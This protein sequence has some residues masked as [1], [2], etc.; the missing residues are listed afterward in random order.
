MVAQETV[1]KKY[2]AIMML[3]LVQGCDGD[4]RDVTDDKLSTYIPAGIYQGTDNPTGETSLPADAMI[5]SDGRVA[6]IT[7]DVPRVFIGTASGAFIPGKVYTDTVS[8]PVTVQLTI[9]SGDI[10]SGTY[11]SSSGDGTFDLLANPELY[12]RPSSLEKLEGEW[13]DD[14]FTSIAGTTTWVI[15]ADGT[16]TVSSTSGCTAEGAF[17]TIDPVKNEYDLSM[18]IANCQ[19]FDGSYTGF[20]FVKDT[21]AIDDAISLVFHNGSIG[22]IAQPVRPSR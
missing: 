15:Q 19:D 2:I 21:L 13:I 11:I 16:F 10:V 6:F 4:D 5:I 12:N 20:A 14:V 22:G 17:S 9:V 7:P 1:M 8:A 18:D 3:I